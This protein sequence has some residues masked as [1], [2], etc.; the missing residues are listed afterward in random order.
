MSRVDR[1][2]EGADVQ[3]PWHRQLWPWL[4]MLMPGL[5][6]V[7]GAITLWLALSTNN[8]LVVD[9]YYRE[10]KAINR[11]LARDDAARKLG[12]QARIAAAEGGGI[13]IR[14]SGTGPVAA[15]FLTLRL[16]H[17]TR[18]ELDRIATLSSVGGGV[19]RSAQGELPTSGRWNV[20]LEDPDRTWRLTGAVTGF[21][22]PMSLGTNMK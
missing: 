17:A 4:L 7:G 12:L 18:A 8:A 1:A 13:E 19:Y 20:L 14:L 3:P 2:P 10:G 6:I 21:S 9:D 11:Q 16:V 22:E 5:A 15:P